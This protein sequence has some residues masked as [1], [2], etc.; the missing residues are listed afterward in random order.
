LPGT[1]DPVSTRLSAKGNYIMTINHEKFYIGVDV[2]K[3]S[4]DIYHLHDKQYTQFTNDAKGI[5]KLIHYLSSIS[6]AFIVM[7]ATGGYEKPL[8]NAIAKAHFN[9]A[10]VNPRQIRDFAK[11]MGR[12]AKTD[13]IDAYV[14]AL[15]AQK[16]QPH[17]NVDCNENQQHL[18]DLNARR[19]QLI[20]MITME[21]NRLDKASKISKK[22]IERIIKALEKELEAINKELANL[23][24]ADPQ[25]AQIN[26]LL[27]TIKGVG[28]VVAAGIIAD[29]PE[30]GTLGAKQISALA[31]LAPLNRDSGTLRGVRTIW[32]GRATVR[33]TIYMSTI[34][35]IRHNEKIK[36]F[37]DRLCAA[38]KTKKSA[39][40][41][42]MHKLIII[43]NAM[44][45]NNQPW[46]PAMS[47]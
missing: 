42:C 6:S 1:F 19:R 31:G 28:P 2:S 36:A 3:A 23:I 13:R 33:C 34:V 39:I 35:A 7:E 8:A 43:M 11:A 12:L 41:A 16:M 44:I 17:A 18:A 47:L 38:G 22:S 10:I 46:Q 9:A 40:V 4:L 29:L 24:Q 26:A 30:L 37:Y 45:K 25:K 15:F 20:D 27:T 5:K 21:K 14:I 32:G